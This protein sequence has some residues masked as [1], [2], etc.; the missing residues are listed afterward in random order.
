VN[1]YEPSTLFGMSSESENGRKHRPRVLKGATIIL[2]NNLSEIACTVR[3]QHEGGAELYVQGI[4]GLPQEFLLYV[5]LDGVAYRTVV[6]WRK[7][8]RMGGEFTGTEPKPRRHY[9]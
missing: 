9:G 5:P 4:I 2:S 3:N 6:R 8:D 1:Q 7:G